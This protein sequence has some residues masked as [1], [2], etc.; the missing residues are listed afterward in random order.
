M[1]WRLGWR[2]SWEI[3]SYGC[4]LKWW[5]PQNTPKW[6][7]FVGKPMVVGYHH[8]RK[9]PHNY[10]CHSADPHISPTIL[11]WNGTYDFENHPTVFFILFSLITSLTDFFDFNDPTAFISKAS[12]MF[13]T[14]ASSKAKTRCCLKY[15]WDD[16]NNSNQAI[17]GWLSSNPPKNRLWQM[18]Q[19]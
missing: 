15:S 16:N 17:K 2:E 10:I 12:P 6:S 1:P 11:W 4:F 9:P 5:Y 7:F 13:R 3:T 14:C 18:F 8:F 19:K